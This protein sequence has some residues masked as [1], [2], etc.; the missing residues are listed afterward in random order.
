MRFGERISELPRVKNLVQGTLGKMLGVNFS[1][2]SKIEKAKLDSGDYPSEELIHKLADA[3]DGDEDESLILAKKTSERLR[4]R[5]FER[6]DAC[7][8]G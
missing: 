4:T 6:P 3:L 7:R 1:Y 5:I 2:V 8:K